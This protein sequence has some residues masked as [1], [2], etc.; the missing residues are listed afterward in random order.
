MLDAMGPEVRSRYFRSK[1]NFL[2]IFLGEIFQRRLYKEKNGN[3]QGILAGKRM[4]RADAPEVSRQAE[5]I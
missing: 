2:K 5:E 1:A 4:H 3:V